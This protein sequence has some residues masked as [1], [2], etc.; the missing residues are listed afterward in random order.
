M[1]FLVFYQLIF[2]HESLKLSDG[3]DFQRGGADE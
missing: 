2:R 1:I 3:M